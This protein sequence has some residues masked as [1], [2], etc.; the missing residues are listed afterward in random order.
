MTETSNPY[1]PPEADIEPPRPEGAAGQLLDPP[2]ACS[3][4]RGGSWI[5][6]GWGLLQAG[7]GPFIGMFLIS[8]LI[9][10]AIGMIPL[11]G[12]ASG[13]L[14]PF[15]FAG[16]VVAC[17]RVRTEGNARFE[18]LFAGFSSHFAPLAIAALIY[19][20]AN[21]VATLIAILVM[22]VMIGSAAVIT[23]GFDPNAVNGPP[24][25]FMLSL[26]LGMLI[27]FA[28]TLPVMMLIWFAPHLIVL[29]DQAPIDAMKM[30]FQGCLRNIIPFLVY[31]VIAIGLFLFG[32]IPL[33]LGLLIV[34][35]WLT[36]ANYI[37]YREIYIGDVD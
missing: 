3:A 27:Y 10:M 25:Q 26:L 29:H 24:V 18:D 1:Q 34:I 22:S 23:G 37:A 4:A 7:M 19:L 31:S 15:F 35:P 12:M 16:W 13:L 14:M 9:L 6:R 36:C 21:V 8:G 32:L 20:A 17:E 30:S 2:N 33:G 5:A 11:L 28:I